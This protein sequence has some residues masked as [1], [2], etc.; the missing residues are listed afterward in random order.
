MRSSTSWY[1]HLLTYL[2]T[3]F[4]S[5]FL[6][7]FLRQKV[8]NICQ[9]WCQDSEIWRV[10]SL[11]IIIKIQEE[12]N[13]LYVC[14]SVSRL[15]SLLKLYKCRIISSCVR[16]IFLKFFG[17]IPE[18]FIHFFWTLTNFFYVCQSVSWL[19][20]LLKLEKYRNISSSR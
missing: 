15:T 9:Y 8:E 5:P 13:C 19:T 4:L 6:P 17:H 3:P 2:L 10:A 16:D 12:P 7:S 11:D 18:I 14:Q 1:L 20:L